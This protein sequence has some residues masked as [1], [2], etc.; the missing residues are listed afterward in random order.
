MTSDDDKKTNVS[1][2]SHAR[3]VSRALTEAARRARFSTRSRRAFSS[4]GFEARRGARAMRI[5]VWLSFFVIVAAPSVAAAV[6]YGLIASDQYVA[7]AQFTV[8][9]GEPPTRDAIAATTGIPAMAIIQDTQIVVN[10]IESRAAVEKLDAALNLR[11]IYSR[12]DIDFLARLKPDEP[13][14]RVVRYWWRMTDASIIMP[15]GIIRFRVRAFTADD[16]Q[17]LG[18]AVIT[19]SEQLIN[20]LNRRMFADAVTNAERELERTAAR[21]AAKSAALEKARNEEGVLDTEKTA[22]AL[23]KLITDLKAQLATMQAEYDAQLQEVS[24]NAPQLLTFKARIDAARGQIAD[25]EAKLTSAEAA[26]QKGRP[27]SVAM[28]KFAELDLEQQIAERLYAGAATSLEVARLA[29]EHKLMYLNTFVRPVAPQEARY[30]YRF[31]FSLGVAIGCLAAW[32]VLCGAVT[33]A[34]NHMA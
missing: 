21:L 9:G 31:L 25:F 27:L 34:R 23:N 10:F 30:P 32:G 28:T 33:L 18:D 12:D 16:A 3:L 13:I 14:E 26:D 29:A 17:K 11:Q 19:I 24:K 15:G 2:L 6:Y 20:E 4:G 8:M 7:E 22:T 5:F 1:A